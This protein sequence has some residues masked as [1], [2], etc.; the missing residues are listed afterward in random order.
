MVLRWGVI[1]LP[2][3]QFLLPRVSLRAVGSSPRV[4]RLGW[5][6]SERIRLAERELEAP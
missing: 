6:R 2:F 4:G 3:N 5:V 1:V